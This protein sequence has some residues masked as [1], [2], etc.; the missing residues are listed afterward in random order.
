MREPNFRAASQLG[1]EQADLRRQEETSRSIKASVPEWISTG[2]MV[3]ASLTDA[4]ETS[5]THGLKRSIRGWML[6]S[7]SGTAD[8]VSVKQTGSDANVVKL[9]NVGATGAL[10]FSLWVW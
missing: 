10:G 8:R 9:Q 5:V 6:V 7:P 2:R 1:P 3:T 4:N